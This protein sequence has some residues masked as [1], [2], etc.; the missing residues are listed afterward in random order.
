MPNHY[1]E[2]RAKKASS[3]RLATLKKKKKLW[4]GGDTHKGLWGLG[5]NTKT[6][7]EAKAKVSDENASKVFMRR[8]KNASPDTPIINL[9]NPNSSG[10][11]AKTSGFSLFNP[12]SILT[13]K[14]NDPENTQNRVSP[15]NKEFYKKP[16]GRKKR[17]N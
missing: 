2:H 10:V 11:E 13:G 5:V 8:L 3:A 17:K 9:M 16:Y 12:E 1:G 7:K 4:G 15:F 14:A 6:M